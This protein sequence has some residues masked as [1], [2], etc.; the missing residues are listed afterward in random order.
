MSK[1]SVKPVLLS[2][3]QIA[4]LQRIQEVER[5]KSPLGIAPTIHEIARGLIN[6]ALVSMNKSGTYAAN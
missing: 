2:K 3:E 1:A 5:Q 6:S 4:A